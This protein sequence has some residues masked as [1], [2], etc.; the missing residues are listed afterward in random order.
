MTT[1]SF[2][3]I[4]DAELQSASGGFFVGALVKVGKA[5]F[6]WAGKGGAAYGGYKAAEAIDGAIDQAIG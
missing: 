6:K 3:L 2:E 5:L 4:S 1:Q